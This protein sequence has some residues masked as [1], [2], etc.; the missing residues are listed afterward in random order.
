M[1]ETETGVPVIAIDGPS[2]AGKGTLCARLARRLGWH[3]LDSGAL[4]RLVALDALRSE[5]ALEDTDRLAARALELDIVFELADDGSEPA[6]RL[7]G[8]DVTRAIREDSVG[9]AAS[10]VA[11]Q[12]PVRAAL[13]ERQRAFRR[14]PGLI[15]DGRDMGTVVFPEAPLKIF[16]TASAEERAQRRYR[17]L[18]EKGLDA[19]L[20]ALFESIRDRDECDASRAAAPLRPAE[21]AISLDSTTMDVD[22]VFAA[23]ETEARRRGLIA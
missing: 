20:A 3:L 6:V 23:V 22:E 16:L 7:A 2:G 5:T 21:D 18:I 1:T 14:P 12:P 10:V 13:I 8:D 17:Q 15:A 11:A 9:Q 19:N 4:Y